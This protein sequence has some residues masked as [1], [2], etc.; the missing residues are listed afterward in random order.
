MK[1]E[2]CPEGGSEC[3]LI[4]IYG[5][6]AAEF[7]L[8]REGIKSLLSSEAIQLDELTGFKSIKGTKLKCHKS[9]VDKGIYNLKGNEFLCELTAARWKQIIGLLEPFC[10]DNKRG[11]FY[12]WLDETSDIQLLVSIDGHW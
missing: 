1:I 6:T 4:R 3:P 7:C 9:M 5:G 8:L 2:Y 11:Q 10:K 12:Q